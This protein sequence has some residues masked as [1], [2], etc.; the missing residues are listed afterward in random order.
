MNRVLLRNGVVYGS[1]AAPARRDVLF[2][3]GRVAQLGALETSA[4]TLVYDCG[5][6][7]VAPG[8]ID[9]HSHS[10]VETLRARREKISQG[11]TTEVVGNCGFSA[12]PCGSVEA[13]EF[14]GGILHGRGEWGWRDAGEYLTAAAQRSLTSVTSLIGHGMLRTEVAGLR[15]GELTETEL[16]RMSGLL[17]EAL[18]AGAAGLSTG[19]EYAPGS[20]AP[21]AELERLCGVVYATHMRNYAGGLLEA[22][23]EQLDLARRTG[24]RLQI[25]HLQAVGA[26]NWHLQARALERIEAA[27]DEGVDVMFDCYPY[28]AGSTVLTQWLPQRALDGGIAAMLARIAGP[29]RQAIAD[30]VEA[31]VPQAWEDLV[32]SSVAS[33]VNAGLAGRSL[34]AIAEERGVAPA[35]LVLDLL[36]EETGEV[37]ILEF[38]QSMENLRA[39]LSHPLGLVASDGFYVDGRP[40]PRLYGAFPHFLGECRRERGWLSLETA[41]DKI[42]SGPA[43][44][45]G[46]NGRGVLSPGASAD[47]VVFDPD[48]VASPATY[49]NPVQAPTGIRWV[50][51]DGRLAAAGNGGDGGGHA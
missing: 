16:D 5:G 21:A 15:Q 32:V 8:F 12:F 36:V 22:L 11:V 42:S 14:A 40:H 47:V 37:H 38:N 43:Q 19:L 33:T 26:R 50:F 4:D 29:D 48:T 18:E 23:D 51:R 27:R 7:A 2:E 10:D 45:F 17:A 30:E 25:S 24:C 31:S 44:R 1:G 34:A 6:M 49:E 39:L 41:L 46:L 28:V 9:V 20:S 13:R 3:E 35:V